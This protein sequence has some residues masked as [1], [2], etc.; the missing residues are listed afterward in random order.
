MEDQVLSIE[1]MKH[2]QELGADTSKASC[3]WK[4]YGYQETGHPENFI[5]KNRTLYLGYCSGSTFNT[6]CVPTFT[7]LDLIGLIP[8]R[9]KEKYVFHIHKVGDHYH[10]EYSYP[11]CDATLH[12]SYSHNLL[13]AAYDM[14]V[15]Y[16]TK[17]KT[18]NL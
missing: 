13:E 14:Y 17:Y 3:H 10:L 6:R 4:I 5:E 16:L 12:T 11:G 18:S 7:L 15:W 9:L 2:L 1:Q 8:P